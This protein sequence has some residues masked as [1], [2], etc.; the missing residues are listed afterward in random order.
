[1]VAFANPGVAVFRPIIEQNK[2]W[3]PAKAADQ[4]VEEGL[5]LRVDPMQIH[6]D[7]DQRLNLRLL[8]N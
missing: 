8:Q 5:G 2:Q 3:R 4:K 1:M 6:K 7:Y